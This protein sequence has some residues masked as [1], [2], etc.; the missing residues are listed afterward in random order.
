M[1]S[2]KLLGAAA[3]SAALGGGAIAGA[4]LGAPGLTGAQEAPDESTDEAPTTTAD[5]GQD[6]GRD[7]RDERDERDDEV[8]RAPDRGLLHHPPLGLVGPAF[9]VG[10]DTLETA[11]GVLGMSE[12]ELRDALEDGSSLAQLAEER[13]V[14]VQA[15]VDALVAAATSELDE[16]VAE[17]K[18]DLPEQIA[19]LVERE[20]DGPREHVWEVRGPG[21]VDLLDLEAAAGALGMSEEELRDALGD[22]ASLEDVAEERGVDVQVVVDAL[23]AAAT[24]EIDAEVAEGDLDA[25]DAADLKEDLRD[26]VERLVEDGPGRPAFAGPW[27]GGHGRGGWR[28]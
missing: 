22:G 11:A 15:L 28:G 24:A 19:D 8:R 26:L 5:P 14:D 7:E 4:L 10:L 6:D 27:F 21:G 23:V 12:D 17:L 3:M 2:R 20:L 13:G 18:E 9:G 1:R 25:D 16:R